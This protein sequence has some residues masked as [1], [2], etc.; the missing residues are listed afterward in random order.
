MALLLIL[1]SNVEYK[2]LFQ[3]H[4]GCGTISFSERVSFGCVTFCLLWRPLAMHVYVI[5][6]AIPVAFAFYPT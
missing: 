4:I 5:T 6:N 3:L 1:Y 2:W